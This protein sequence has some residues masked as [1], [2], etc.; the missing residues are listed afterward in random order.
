MLLQLLGNIILLLSLLWLV[1][2]LSLSGF[3]RVYG[4]GHKPLTFL[5][6]RVDSLVYVP[7]FLLG[8]NSQINTIAAFT[9]NKVKFK[10]RREIL[11]GADGG[12]FA[13]DWFEDERITLTDSSPIVFLC[14]GINGGS[15]EPFVQHFALRALREKH[16]RP[17]CY[18][19][20]GCAG[21]KITTPRT[22][23]GGATED[24][25]IA[26]K[27]IAKRFP[28]APIALVGFSMGGNQLAK[29]L[30]EFKSSHKQIVPPKHVV[31][32]DSLPESVVCGVMT[33]CP[34]DYVVTSQTCIPEQNKQIGMN[35][36]TYFNKNEE[37]IKSHRFYET[38]K[39]IEHPTTDDFYH[40]IASDVFG[41]P[42]LRDMYADT[43]AALFVAG[44][45]IPTLFITSGNDPVSTQNAVPFREISHNEHTALLQTPS[46][47]HLGQ[48][49]ALSTKKKFDEDLMFEYVEWYVAPEKRLSNKAGKV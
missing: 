39:Q 11:Q 41:Y 14:H 12:D 27:E 1:R 2:W 46:G 23:N 6:S 48:F 22:Y 43:S 4:K 38:Y 5:G 26:M 49:K 21:A 31:D 36:K 19:Y 32:H 24:I 9:L 37:M 15:G 10:P 34:F 30:G 47:G 16:Y 20:R 17:V 18:I 35:C 13:L 40:Y 8:L 3:V 28:Q 45:D 42:S 33:G 7:H 25:H 29:Y 44:I